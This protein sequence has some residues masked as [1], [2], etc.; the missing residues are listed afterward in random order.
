MNPYRL[1]PKPKL[2]FDV[3][4]EWETDH[5]RAILSVIDSGTLPPVSALGLALRSVTVTEL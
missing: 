3:I 2:L 1:T 4:L 5:S